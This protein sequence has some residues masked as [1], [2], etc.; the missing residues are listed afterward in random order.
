MVGAIQTFRYQAVI[1][2]LKSRAA[3][4]AAAVAA[5]VSMAIYGEIRFL[6]ITM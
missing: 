6:S 3:V 4:L 5:V 2:A 1:Q